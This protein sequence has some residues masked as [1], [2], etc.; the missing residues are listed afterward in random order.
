MEIANVRILLE[1][2]ISGMPR[3]ANASE[4]LLTGNMADAHQ[5][6]S[7]SGQPRSPA[8]VCARTRIFAQRLTAFLSTLCGYRRLG[9]N[10]NPNATTWYAKE[11]GGVSIHSLREHS[12][13][14]T[15]PVAE[16]D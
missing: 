6:P 5:L 2:V 9:Y 3:L 14:E 7:H 12:T 10:D 1:P 11:L 13:T 8:L 4:A 16:I 15:S